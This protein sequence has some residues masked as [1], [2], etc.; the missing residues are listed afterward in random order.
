MKRTL[1]LTE[2][3]FRHLISESVKKALMEGGHLY[4]KDDDG[5]VWTNSKETYRGVPGSVY[6]WHGEWSDPEILWD[7]VELNANDVEDFL[8]STYK[9]VCDE[10]GENP[11]DEGF[12]TWAENE[13]IASYLDEIAWATS[14]RS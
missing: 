1:R 4:S 6:I 5:N 3:E 7:G 10:N 11:T 12:E 8:W 13:D 2:S 9:E 14:Q